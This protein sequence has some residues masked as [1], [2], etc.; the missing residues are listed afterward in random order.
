MAKSRRASR[1]V[2]LAHLMNKVSEGKREQCRSILSAADG[3]IFCI[4]REGHE[5]DH[6]G[7]RAQWNENG[8]V[9]INEPLK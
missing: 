7:Y 8:R 1:S 9:P 5:G 6:R 3:A 4:K 2:V